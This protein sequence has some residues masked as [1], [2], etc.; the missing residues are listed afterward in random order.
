[1]PVQAKPKINDVIK[2]TNNV[3][4]KV[5]SQTLPVNSS[6]KT[7]SKDPNKSSKSST[8]NN[9]TLSTNSKDNKSNRT[10]SF[11][12]NLDDINLLDAPR[13][14]E[15][16][17]REMS[18]QQTSTDNNNE[19][20]SSATKSTK[21]ITKESKYE[22]T[23][24]EN[25]IK[26]SKNSSDYLLSSKTDSR[27]KKSADNL[28]KPS[29]SRRRPENDQPQVARFYLDDLEKLNLNNLQVTKKEVVTNENEP[30]KFI[31]V[32]ENE[33]F[34]FPKPVFK[35]PDTEFLMKPTLRKM[36]KDFYYY[37][38]ELESESESIHS[39]QNEYDDIDE[40]DL[41]SISMTTTPV[42]GLRVILRNDMVKYEKEKLEEKL[43]EFKLKEERLKQE[44][45]REERLKEK[46]LTEERLKEERSREEMMREEK[47]KEE[48][49]KE[50]R[51]RFEKL[52]E[53]RIKEEMTRVQKSNDEKLKADKVII[54]S[55]KVSDLSSDESSDNEEKDV[56]ESESE[57][58]EASSL[59]SNLKTFKVQTEKSFFNDSYLTIKNRLLSSIN[60]QLSDRNYEQKTNALTKSSSFSNYEKISDYQSLK[61]QS[62]FKNNPS[63]IKE[64]I[65]L[66]DKKKS[67]DTLNQRG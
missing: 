58:N 44:M 61:P 35:T 62:N 60:E 39:N 56:F 52:I 54:I 46:S 7:R 15:N 24:S 37:L 14:K 3:V 28:D 16:K 5:T 40:D 21:E 13:R 6:I 53:A 42:K 65:I 26:S 48:R 55:N 8:S 34:K 63:N 67:F 4:K 47:L 33:N 2:E 32:V 38:D 51:L 25:N 20:K 22:K 23:M 66:R 45:L 12:E 9:N 17:V 27:L 57:E 64:Q 43:K 1:M 10:S 36:P 19:K 30:E 31:K 29:K 49:L 50:E 18:S 11:I 41:K 59:S